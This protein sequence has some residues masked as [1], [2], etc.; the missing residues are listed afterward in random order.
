LGKNDN[1]VKNEKGL[2]RGRDGLTA[3]QESFVSHVTSGKTPSESARLAGYSK[4]NTDSWRLQQ[5][6]SV[7]AA[8]LK[9]IESGVQTE[10]IALA[11]RVHRELL[12]SPDTPP[13]VKGQMVKLAYD[14][15]GIGENVN[16]IKA[17]AGKALAEMTRD[18]LQIIAS[19]GASES[20]D[21][22]TIIDIT[23]DKPM[24]S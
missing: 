19:G 13:S 1:V 17:I 21:R 7:K 23:P 2:I 24:E 16:D 3:K 8:I 9:T 20:K 15:A 10:T 4:P 11:A 14:T 18:E 12:E 6:P 5:T 22:P